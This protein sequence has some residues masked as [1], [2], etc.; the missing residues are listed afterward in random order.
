MGTHAY[1]LEL[2]RLLEYSKK[3][4]PMPIIYPLCCMF[5]KLSLIFFYG[6]LS[7][8][9]RYR[10]AMWSGAFFIVASMVG[11][12]IATAIPCKPLEVAWNP[13]ISGTCIDRPAAYEATAIVALVA[14]VWLMVLPIPIVIRLQIPWQQ[15]VGL[16]VMFGI[17]TM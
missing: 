17:G 10:I 7:S 5:A 16:M 15:K 6:R 14:D 9:L 2:S 4:Y 11:L 8:G 3:F 12:A 1:E 13:L